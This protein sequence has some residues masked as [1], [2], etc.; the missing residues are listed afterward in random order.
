L[1]NRLATHKSGKDFTSYYFLPIAEG[2]A[3]MDEVERHYICKLKPK[4]NRRVPSLNVSLPVNES[5]SKVERAMERVKAGMTPYASAR[6]EG[7]AMS[8]L[9]RSRL[10]REW[11][12][13]QK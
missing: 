7:M 11:K 4:L 13:S 3:D 6:L 10:Y 8:T 2:K 9:Y 5:M 12:H 1:Y